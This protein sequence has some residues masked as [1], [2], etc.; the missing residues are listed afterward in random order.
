[1]GGAYATWYVLG[2][3]GGGIGMGF[4]TAIAVGLV[5]AI[6][7]YFVVLKRIPPDQPMGVFIAT[8]GISMFLQNVIARFVGPDDR[9]FPTLLPPAFH[10]VGPILVSDSQL[11][12]LGLTVGLVFVL[13]WWIGR[14]SMGRE[15]RAVSE[16]RNVARMLGV[17]VPFVMVTTLVVA[18]VIAGITGF[19]FGN[20]YGAINPFMS[21]PMALKMFVV[22]LVAGTGSFRGAVAV[23]LGL[24]VLEAL[25]ASYIGSSWQDMGG[26][27]AL[28]AVLFLRPQGL[29]GQ[30]ARAT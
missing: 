23:G 14:T 24:G 15:I 11:L 28:V 29:F 2:A 7:L 10:H 27:V 20:L 19:V 9:S 18:C 25:T 22:S 6:V 13:F 3:V 16:N 5:A 12:L 8:L 21:Q 30:P 17:N 4:V 1:M 26:L